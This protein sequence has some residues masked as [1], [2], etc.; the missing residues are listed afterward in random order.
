MKG[1]TLMSRVRGVLGALAL[2]A[3]SGA[4]SSGVSTPTLPADER[5]IVAISPRS[6]SLLLGTTRT[7][8]ASVT[9]PAGV[10]RNVPVDFVSLSPAVLTVSGNAVT[11]V[12]VGVAQVVARAGTSTD[13]ATLRVYPARVEL[14]LTPSAV[15]ASLGDTIAFE[16]T[17][18]SENNAATEVSGVTWTLSDTTAARL[19]GDGA[20]S[21][22]AEGELQV[23]ATVGNSTAMASVTVQASPI[24]SVSIVPSNLSLVVGA[25]SIVRAEARDGRGRLV[26]GATVTWKTSRASVASVDHDG[27]ITAVAPGGALVTA[28]VNG[29]SASAAINVAAAPAASVNIS[30]PNDSLGT[31]RSMQATATPLDASGAPI[32]GR[33]LAWQSSNPSVATISSSGTIVAIAAGSTNISVICDGK[34]ATQKLVIATPVARSVAV[35]PPVAQLPIGSTSKLSAEVRDQFGIVLSGQVVTWSSSASSIVSVNATGS[36]AASALG[37]ATVRATSGALVGSSTVS[38]H[39][40]PVATVSVSPQNPVIE[41]GETQALAA[42]PRDSAGNVLSNRPVTWTSDA[43]AVASVSAAGAVQGLSAGTARIT[44]TIEGK[45]AS[46]SVTVEPPPPPTVSTVTVTLNSPSITVGQATNAHARAY[47]ANGLELSGLPV[48][49]GTDAPVIATVSPDGRVRGLKSGSASITA[50]VGGESGIASIQVQ[51]SAPLPVHAVSV[52]APATSLLVGD[53]TVLVVTLTDSTGSALSGRTISYT[54]SSTS[55]ATVSPSGRVCA[56]GVGTATVTVT[57]EGKS[58][59]LVFTV[60]S[61]PTA[62]PAPVATVTVALQSATLTVGQGTQATAT[63]RDASSNVLTGRTIAWTSSNVA[64]ATVTQG[65]YVTAVGA[66]S[67]TISAQSEGKS[68]GAPVT[69]QAPAIVVASVQ[70]TLS[71]TS[72]AVGAKS[73]ATAVARDSSGAV[74]TGRP[75]TWA[76]TSGASVATISGGT[77]STV[78]ATGASAGKA[79]LSASVSGV[80]GTTT[81]TVTAPPPPPPP[82]PPP[83]SVAQPAAPA[84]LNFSYPSVTGKTWVVKAGDNLQTALNSAQRGDEVV[85]QAGATFTGNYTLPSKPGSAANG[86]VLVRSDKSAQLPPQGTRVTPAHAGLMPKIVTTNS[87][88]ALATALGASGWWISGVEVTIGANVSMNYGLLL[89]GDGSSKQN[90]LSLVA[91]DLVIERSYVHATSTSQ[92]T[93]CIAL[94]SARSAVQDSYVHECHASGFDSQAIVGWNGPGPFKIVNNTLAGA[95][96]NIMFGGS[97]PAIP[98]LIPSDIEVRRNYIVTPASWKGVWTKKN[99]FETK[100]AQRLLIEGNVF[101]GSWNDGQVGYA[102]VL[103]SANQGGKCTWCASRDIAVRNNIIRN[104]GAGFNLTGREG[105]NPYPVGELMSRVLI[106]QNIIEDINTG[107]YQGEAKFIQVLQNLKDLTVRSNTMTA[108][109]VFGQFFSVGSA[110]AATNVDFQNNVVTHGQYGLFAS[111]SGTGE[112]ALANLGGLVVFKNYVMI[113]SQRSGYPNGTFA[114]DLAAAQATGRGASTSAVSAATAGVVIP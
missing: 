102:F 89:L 101:D 49:F 19:L 28:T 11:A 113:G 52:S 67:A 9:N 3:C 71:P 88:A 45:S 103:K 2:A 51:P 39:N 85:I 22:I 48:Q 109:G 84:L 96:E 99:L 27:M 72:I 86:W 18:V 32:T 76:V 75:V 36:I 50:T 70:V 44:A 21:T 38:V 97:D 104:A 68:G 107:V 98:D 31:G 34:I 55:V 81:L 6:D 7:L 1:F 4:E 93:R 111:A 16:A 41:V 87:S 15:A 74:I 30:L 105:S 12:G 92:T 66:G 60:S 58:G 91:S 73:T 80:S 14:R 17:I 26:K 8:A 59:S 25:R 108:P 83:S 46:T 95:G 65:G 114:A 57:S 24:T 63:L 62:P 43:P 77:T 61:V 10:S 40:I 106:E 112:G 53:S 82:P 56:V 69:A 35:L 110:T 47:D 5:L 78:T 20:I 54:S 64:V 37:T 94:N 79:T 23:I 90:S 100:N 29:L 13:T 33:P 42:Q